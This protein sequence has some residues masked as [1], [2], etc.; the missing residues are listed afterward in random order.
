MDG[1]ERRLVDD[2]QMVVFV[3]QAERRHFAGLLERLAPEQHAIAF[4]N[5]VV[6]AQ[7]AAFGIVRAGF[8]DVLRARATRAPELR[9]DED[10]EPPPRGFRGHEQNAQDRSL[11]NPFGPSRYRIESRR[12]LG[13]RL[14]PVPRL[15]QRR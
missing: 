13:A 8:D 1:N 6:R 2:E 12:G 14:P 3:D 10:I 15:S 4:A 11:G 7:S 9:R 5:S